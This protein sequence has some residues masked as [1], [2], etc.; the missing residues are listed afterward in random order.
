[1]TES[2]DKKRSQDGIMKVALVI[3][4][5]ALTPYV[6]ESWKLY[7]FIHTHKL[8]IPEY[9][10]ATFPELADLWISVASALTMLV[11]KAILAY[12]L[13]PIVKAIR[14]PK[15]GETPE[16]AEAEGR[17]A[18]EQFGK[19]LGSCF[20]AFYGLIV[21]QDKPW[22]PWY[23]GGEHNIKMLCFDSPFT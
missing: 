22:L 14:R 19:L 6:Y 18:I 8:Q 12:I 20:V 23:L 17:V 15:A 3:A 21:M 11:V 7:T 9:K 16:A 13:P 10:D 2:K 5:L 4:L 1:M